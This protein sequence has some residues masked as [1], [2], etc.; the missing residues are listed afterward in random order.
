VFSSTR[1]E[2]KPTEDGSDLTA[3]S[4]V[5]RRH[6]VL[7]SKNFNFV[8]QHPIMSY[9]SLGVY[10]NKNKKKSLLCFLII[11]LLRWNFFLVCISLHMKITPFGKKIGS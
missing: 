6:V 4:Y 2:R 10:V 7:L 3:Q 1:P 8:Y 11:I 5:K 9:S